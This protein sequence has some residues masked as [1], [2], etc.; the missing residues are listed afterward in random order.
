MDLDKLTQEERFEIAA[1]NNGLGSPTHLNGTVGT[2]A[3]RY[4]LLTPSAAALIILNSHASNSLY[5]SFDGTTYF[6]ISAANS[7]AV[8]S[9]SVPYVYLKGSGAGTTFEILYY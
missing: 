5:A 2:D 4:T 9:V 7:L 1:A 6:T 8:D 3:V